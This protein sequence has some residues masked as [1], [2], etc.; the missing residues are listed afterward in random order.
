MGKGINA[1]F[2]NKK[3]DPDV[4]KVLKMLDELLGDLPEEKIEKFANSDEFELYTR[5]LD[6]YGVK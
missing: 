4:L 3:V 5:V 2:D 6:R 1:F